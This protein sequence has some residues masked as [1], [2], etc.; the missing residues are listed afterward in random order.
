MMIFSC[1]K[2]KSKFHK[3]CLIVIFFVKLILDAQERYRAP[4]KVNKTSKTYSN[5]SGSYIENFSISMIKSRSKFKISHFH[6]MRLRVIFPVP[7]DN[8]KIILECSEP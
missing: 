2:K 7:T 3:K 1:P 4:L 5:E 8:L 6:L